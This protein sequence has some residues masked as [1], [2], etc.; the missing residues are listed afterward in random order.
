VHSHRMNKHKIVL[1]LLLAVALT[2]PLY[3]QD[4]NAFTQ[5][6]YPSW[7]INPP[8]NEGYYVGVGLAR[9]SNRTEAEFRKEADDAAWAE[10][11]SKISV[12]IAGSMESTEYE[13][14]LEESG[15]RETVLQSTAMHTIKSLSSA[16]LEGI[17]RVNQTFFEIDGVRYYAV[18]WRLSEVKYQETLDKHEQTAIAHFRLAKSLPVSDV[19]GRLSNLV[20]SLEAVML[21]NG[22]RVEI[23]IGGADHILNAE[24]PSELE[25]IISTMTV[26]GGNTRQQV[27]ENELPQASLIFTVYHNGQPLNGTRV[28]YDFIEGEGTFR[29]GDY[30][31]DGAGQ[32]EATITNINYVQGSATVKGAVDLT[33]LKMNSI[34]LPILDDYLRKLGDNLAV[35]YTAV[36][37]KL[38]SD[39]IAITLFAEQG[40]PQTDIRYLNEIFISATKANTGFKV[41]ER[42][43]MEE[44]LEEQNFNAKECSTEECQVLV[45]K[46]LSVRN[47]VY[48]LLWK[49][50]NEYR[51]T[52]KLIN[53]ETG[54]NEHVE[55][56]KFKGNLADLADKGVPAWMATFYESLNVGRLSFI[57]NKRGIKVY[58]GKE[59][60]GEL[61]LKDKK[62]PDGTYKFT[63]VGS[64]YE[65]TKGRYSIVTGQNLKYNIELKKKSGFK[66]F[67]KSLLFPGWGQLYSSD[68]IYPGRRMTGLIFGLSGIAAVALNGQVWL[69]FLDSKKDYENAYDLYMEK[70]A[71]EEIAFYKSIAQEKNDEMLTK[72]DNATIISAITG[73]LWLANAL[74]AAISFPNYNVGLVER[75]GST[76]VS[77]SPNEG[78]SGIELKVGIR[79]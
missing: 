9:A 54:E 35:Y 36:T 28:S 2:T 1:F 57:S 66:A 4:F 7:F 62:L 31:S 8:A 71:L 24:V 22:R 27:K 49:M 10:I 40:I 38:R 21:T 51:G 64:G 46:M 56:V 65:T 29:A 43:K 58:L 5:D 63:F 68:E 73:A 41:M 53:I 26:E 45:G 67:T 25:K 61:P 74:E 48:V 6:G 60:F 76:F 30:M 75:Q 42:N 16:K 55:S 32:C 17:E 34:P 18:L 11:S 15:K 47:M 72:Q 78:M 50:G 39:V 14:T 77:F 23:N 59:F 13:E 70:E 52:I 33:R 20:K 69:D 3:T 12:H 44:I 37:S 79:F 19:M